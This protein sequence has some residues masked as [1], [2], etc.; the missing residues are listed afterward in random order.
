MKKIIKGVRYDTDTAKPL[1]RVEVSTLTHEVL[2][3]KVNEMY[4][5][6]VDSVAGKAIRPFPGLTLANNHRAAKAWAE[7]QMCVDDYERIFGEVSE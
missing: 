3:Q 2:Y 7:E 4:F 5:I 6:F 1:I